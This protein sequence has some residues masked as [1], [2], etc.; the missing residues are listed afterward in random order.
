MNL[1]DLTKIELN[2]ALEQFEQIF[3]DIQELR[4]NYESKLEDIQVTS[5]K[6]IQYIIQID[7]IFKEI[8]III[9]QHSLIQSEKIA[10]DW[11]GIDEET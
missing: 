3:A 5:P 8:I 10:L 9:V 1:D 6:E 11:D 7:D 4:H 2:N